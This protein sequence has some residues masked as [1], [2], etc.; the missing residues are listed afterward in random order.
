MLAAG[1]QRIEGG[2]LEGGADRPANRGPLLDDV[3]AA[4][5][6]GSRCR[7]EE[8]RQHVDG[9]RLAGAV[10]PEEAVDLA[11]RDLE[12]DAGDGRDSALEPPDEAPNLDC[13]LH[14]ATLAMYESCKARR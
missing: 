8:G 7:R 14:A 4:D 2:N 3:E 13:G 12:V 11:R 5:A 1:Q 9:C 10:G 6:C